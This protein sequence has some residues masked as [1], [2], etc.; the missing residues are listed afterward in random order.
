MIPWNDDEHEPTYLHPL[1][2]YAVSRD[3][4]W[5]FVREVNY[6]DSG[7]APEMVW[8]GGDWEVK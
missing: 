5:D 6:A 4:C 1:T 2:G 8:V 3:E 7:E